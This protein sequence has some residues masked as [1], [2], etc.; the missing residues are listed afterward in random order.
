MVTF[1]CPTLIFFHDSTTHLSASHFFGNESKICSDY[2]AQHIRNQ[3]T[4]SKSI[5]SNDEHMSK[6]C[7]FQ[8][9]MLESKRIQ[10]KKKVEKLVK[11]VDKMRCVD[12]TPQVT[13]T[14]A[15]MEILSAATLSLR[16][17]ETEN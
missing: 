13:S 16:S 2:S 11:L 6:T 1:L 14:K 7:I 4:G 8:R 12:D 5:Y 3:P 15:S 10:I 9:C 17:K